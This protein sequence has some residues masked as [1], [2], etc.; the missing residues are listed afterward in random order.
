[1]VAA[2][3][4]AV[5]LGGI[6]ALAYWTGTGGGNGSATVGSP[7]G[8]PLTTTDHTGVSAL[9]P[10]ATVG[11]AL[12]VTNPSTANDAHFNSVSVAFGTLPSGCVAADFSLSGTISVPA[13]GI[14]L[15]AGATSGSLS[16]VTLKMNNTSVSQDACEAT[17]VPLVFT[18]S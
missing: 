17:T 9:V 18:V 16:G 1:V 5:G 10:G 11:V 4:A 8:E 13:G 12:T 3:V 7:S 2:V 6:T 15:A 14:D